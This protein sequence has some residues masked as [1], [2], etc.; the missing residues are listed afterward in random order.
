MAGNTPHGRTGAANVNACLLPQNVVYGINEY[1]ERA[2]HLYSN[3]D[4]LAAMKRHLQENRVRLPIF[5][6]PR[7]IKHLEAAYEKM[8]ELHIKGEAPQHIY[9]EPLPEI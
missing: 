8:W 3:R 6:R 2:V 1:V 4:E 9:V 5:D 7:Y